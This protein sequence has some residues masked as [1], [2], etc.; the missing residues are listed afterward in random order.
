MVARGTALLVIALLA[1]ACET[2]R[3]LWPVERLDPYS[4]VNTTIMAE[5]WVYGRDVRAL[6]ANARDYVNVGLVETNR[7][8][9]RAYWLGIVAW[10]T[11]DRSALPAPVEPTRPDIVQFNWPDDSLE[12]RATPGGRNSIGATEPVFA[13]PQPIF[14]DGWY[15]LSLAQ[16]TRLARGPP[17]SVSLVLEGGRVAVYEPWQVRRGALDQF[18]EAT[19]HP[20]R[21]R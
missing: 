16:L 19:G 10:S 7:A 3:D 15:L 8:G 12:L 21:Q 20:E 6:A 13:A 9:Q 11:I 14:E 1:S 17:D 5:P 4:A 18:L 2:G